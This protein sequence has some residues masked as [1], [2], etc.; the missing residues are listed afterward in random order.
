[1][2]KQRKSDRVISRSSRV[3]NA[4]ACAISLRVRAI[5]DLLS[6][7]RRLPINEG[8]TSI[9][10][11]V[12]DMTTDEVWAEKELLSR[13]QAKA[14]YEGLIRHEANLLSQLSHPLLPQFRQIEFR[15][16]A[17]GAETAVL[18]YHWEEG[19]NLRESLSA[20]KSL[21]SETRLIWLNRFAQQL[22]EAIS[23]LHSEG[24]YH[25][26]LAPENILIRKSGK[27]MLLDFAL[28]GRVDDKRLRGL[29]IGGRDFYR[30]PELRGKSSGSLAGD[31]YAVGRILEEAVGDS[32]PIE[33]QAWVDELVDLRQW[34]LELEA[35]ASE[36]LPA[37]A[38]A[39]GASLNLV[40]TSLIPKNFD[41]SV[42]LKSLVLAVLLTSYCPFGSL[43][44]NA[45]PFSKIRLG[46]LRLETPIRSISLSTGSYEIEFVSPQS[47]R[48]IATKTV[49]ITHGSQ[50]KVFEDF[51]NI[52]NLTQ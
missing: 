1:L 37:L 15:A 4:L 35:M 20:L 2:K 43:S 26:D 22:F 44:V 17:W 41:K 39:S 34:P 40:K 33:I 13:Y 52:D 8:G 42:A 27:L 36:A 25:G 3:T 16:T 14:L 32:I 38:S 12:E 31:L 11:R 21:R 5:K 46:S 24:M 9:V 47:G 51:R 23:Y 48:A 49:E 50:F 28:A 10:Y 30:A 29:E 18:S 45:L 6:S 7:L 19:L